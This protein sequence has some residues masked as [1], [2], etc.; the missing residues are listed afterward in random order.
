MFSVSGGSPATRPAPSGERPSSL[1]QAFPHLME[2]LF[3]E[4]G[5]IACLLEAQADGSLSVRDLEEILHLIT[6]SSEFRARLEQPSAYAPS[7]DRQVSSLAQPPTPSAFPGAFL[8]AG[9]PLYHQHCHTP[10]YEY[11]P[12]RR[13]LYNH[14]PTSSATEFHGHLSHVPP[15]ASPERTHRFRN[16]VGAPYP[17]PHARAAIRGNRRLDS[18]PPKSWKGLLRLLPGIANA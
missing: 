14:A 2:A 18:R 17:K 11:E 1:P 16:D 5:S 7:L 12:H 10:P 6:L 15:L 13:S 8:P 3:A 9:P 4:L